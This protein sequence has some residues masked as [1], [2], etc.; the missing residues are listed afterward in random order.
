MTYHLHGDPA[1]IVFLLAILGAATIL[2]GI[3]NWVSERISLDLHPLWHVIPRRFKIRLR[4]DR[5]GAAFEFDGGRQGV[6]LGAF[7]ADDVDQV[8][9]IQPRAA[10][11]AEAD[12]PPEWVACSNVDGEW[13]SLTV[14]GLRI[15]EL[16]P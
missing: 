13:K 14:P 4:W 12:G 11:L 15:R 3:Q 10:D 5:P 9:L 2:S 1:I 6:I 8:L 7:H 16:Q